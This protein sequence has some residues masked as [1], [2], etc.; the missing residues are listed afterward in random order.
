MASEPIVNSFYKQVGEKIRFQRIK[1]QMDQETLSRHLNLSRTTLINIEKGRQRLSLE[2][3]W[4]AANVLVI[5]ISDLLPPMNVKTEDEWATEIQNS[6]INKEMG[7][8]VM[9]WI[10]KVK[11]NS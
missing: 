11:K 8:S 3:A 5:S 10:S 6:G 7:K 4:L 2:H 9:K 1:A